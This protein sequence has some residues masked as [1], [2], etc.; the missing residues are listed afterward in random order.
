V[1]SLFSSIDTQSQPGCSVGI[2][3]RGGFIHR[4]NYGAANLEYGIPLSSK[5]VF[6]IGSNS[7]NLRP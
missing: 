4:G 3:Y 1:D 7:S 2:I 6:R 5:T